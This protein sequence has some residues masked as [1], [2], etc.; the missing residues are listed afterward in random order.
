MSTVQEMNEL[1]R[2]T[3][4]NKAQ[5]GFTLIEL[6]IVV[7]IIGIL[8]AIAIPQYGNYLDR[9]A[10]NACRAEMSNARTVA[11]ANETVNDTD[12]SFSFASCYTAAGG[13]DS[14]LLGAIPGNTALAELLVAGA[15][16]GDTGVVVGTENDGSDRTADF[17]S[18]F[19][20]RGE[21]AID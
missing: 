13:E 12:Q 5:G 14:N 17:P 2:K 8:A 20:A 19:S 16:F 4:L 6:L 15:T 10:E 21:S 9:A 11:I 7:A 1:K 18:V 3:Q